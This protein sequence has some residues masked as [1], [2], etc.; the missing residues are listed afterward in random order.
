MNTIKDIQFKNS[1]HPTFQFDFIKLEDIFTR[2]DMDHSPDQLHRVEFYIILFI[3]EG[4]TKHTIDFLDYPCKKGTLLTI[5]KDQIHRFHPSQSIKGKLLLF[6][7]EF[8]VSYLEQTENQKSI[9]IFNELIS[10]PNIQLS[11]SEFTLIN[12]IINRMK[13][14]YFNQKDEFALSIIRS[15]LHILISHLFRIKS[16]N[17]HINTERKYLKEFV[18]LQELIEQHAFETTKVKEYAHM[19]GRS[20]KTL[21]TITKNIIHKTAKEFIDQI[22]IK[23]IKRL[24]INTN[25]SIKEIAIHA[26]F[27]ETSNFYKYFKRHTKLTPEKFRSHS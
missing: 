1:Q 26:G 24:L 18:N 22:C 5:R 2:T 23:Q 11:D 7:D 10:N 9:L 21:N 20:E 16:K 4:S 6:T 19:M 15:E 27:E 14:E 12:E 3:E 17:K 13:D 8:L 25:Y